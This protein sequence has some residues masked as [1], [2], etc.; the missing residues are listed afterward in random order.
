MASNTVQLASVVDSTTEL[1]D[2]L[3]FTLQGISSS[4]SKP[5]AELETQLQ[6]MR[7]VLRILGVVPDTVA[8]NTEVIG[9][10]EKFG[11]ACVPVEESIKRLSKSGCADWTAFQIEGEDTAAIVRKLHYYVATI[12]I[13][14][15]A[16]VTSVLRHACFDETI[17]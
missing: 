4:L 3:Y 16:D 9:I 14:E 2:S 7:T 11:S 6:A 17:R 5:F 10:V 8:I 13:G 12:I 15:L 1:V